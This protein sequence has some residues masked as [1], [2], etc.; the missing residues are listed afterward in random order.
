MDALETRLAVRELAERYA[1]HVDRRRDV[2]TAELFIEDG[3]LVIEWGGEQATTT[4]RGRAAIEAAMK[5]L[6]RYRVTQHV[7][8]NQLVDFSG[9][10]VRAETYCTASHVYDTAEGPRVF[11]MRIRY[12]DT[13]AHDDEWR[14]AQ[15][16]LVVDWTEDRPLGV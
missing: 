16:H 3:T 13:F 2:A 11:V 4:V 10:R 6:D 15:R 9:E 12:L 5:P 1:S 14:F 8:A 7:I